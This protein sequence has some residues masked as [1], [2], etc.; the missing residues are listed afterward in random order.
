M[1]EEITIL[2]AGHQGLAMAA[3]LSVNGISCN[4]WNRSENHICDIKESKQIRCTG[5]LDG[6]FEIN[7]ISTNIEDVLTKKIMIT[8]P[9]SAHR[10][11]AALLAPYV[12][13]SFTIILNPGRTF[14]ILDFLYTLKRC[15]CQ[16]LPCVAETQTIIYTCRRDSYNSVRLFALKE[17]IPISTMKN[18]DINH[19]LTAIPE[20]IRKHFVPVNSYM[21]TSMDNVGMVL[22]SVPVL[23]NVGWIENKNVQFEYYY[24]GISQSI[25]SVLEKLDKERLAVAKALGYPVESL[26]EWLHRTYQTEGNNLYEHLQSNRYYRGIDAPK[27][28]KHRYL[29]EDIPNG[30]VPLEDIGKMFGV[31]TPVTTSI[32]SFANIVMDCDYRKTGRR[33]SILKEIEEEI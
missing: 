12:D 20:C 31:L 15:G 17:N 1:A 32:I 11:L 26:I 30:L 5:I 3:H 28:I 21:E 29:E 33:Y 8:T 24:D 18:K 10:D 4:L 9:S 13:N 25:A 16:K 2:G 14:G 6:C 23:M 19:V 27:S 22:H 7:K